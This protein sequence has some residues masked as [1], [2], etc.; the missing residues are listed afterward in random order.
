M[1]TK[2]V[3]GLTG[4]ILLFVGLFAPLIS[5]P[6]MGSTNYFQYCKGVA[7]TVLVLAVISLILVL[8]K[9][10]KGLWFTGLG[11]LVLFS[12]T[13]IHIQTKMS[14]ISQIK[15]DMESRLAGNPF[16]GL[17]DMAMMQ[18]I[19]LQWGW[20]V[21]I[22]GAALVITAAALK[23][24]QQEVIPG[25]WGK[26]L[27]RLQIISICGAI[28]LAII[29]LVPQVHHLNSTRSSVKTSSISEPVP[30]PVGPPLQFPPQQKYNH[31][32]K[33]TTN[34]NKIDDYT[35][36]NLDDLSLGNNLK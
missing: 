2:Q 35:T 24:D 1:N 17:A 7:V 25:I 6:I 9:K 8:T 19:Q 34:Y 22:V 14:Q 3:F 4:S 33:I 30:V 20:P 18:S 21:L 15:A 12:F 29:I 10:Y 16:R 31:N 5:F 26:K 28:I 36:V 13:F 32:F 11:S 23:E 27:T